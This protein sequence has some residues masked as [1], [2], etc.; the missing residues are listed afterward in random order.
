MIFI[1]LTI[2]LLIGT[3]LSLR[4]VELLVYYAIYYGLCFLTLKSFKYGNDFFLSFDKE[5]IGYIGNRIK[6]A[7]QVITSD[8]EEDRQENRFLNVFETYRVVKRK[9]LSWILF[10]CGIWFFYYKNG[11]ELSVNS[12]VPV[13]SCFF[14]INSF[15]VG[16][17]LVAI[18]LNAVLVA[19][20][21]S[22]DVPSPFYFLYS[23]SCFFSLYLISKT[24][25][26]VLS[27]DLLKKKVVSLSLISLLFF[28][29]CFAFK[30]VL[31]QEFKFDKK[32]E[33]SNDHL[34]KLQDYL[35]K[36]KLDLGDIQSRLQG[37][38]REGLSPK[39]DMNSKHIDEI[40]KKLLQKE[41][42]AAEK[43]KLLQEMQLLM[44]N[45]QN[46][47]SDFNQSLK[48]GNGP[49]LSE[50]EKESFR[51]LNDDLELTDEEKNNL[52]SFIN[53]TKTRLGGIGPSS[54]KD[55]MQS[56]VD[57]IQKSLDGKTFTEK[58]QGEIYQAIRKITA[59]QDAL[60]TKAHREAIKNSNVAPEP[61]QVQK[62]KLLEPLKKKEIPKESQFKKLERILAIACL[63][64]IFF[65]IRR[66]LFKKGITKIEAR[67]PEALK[68]IQDEWKKI[69]K[70]RL[71]PRE[72]VIFHY[73]LF[74][75]SLQKIH[76][77]EH[78]APP[79]C[80][81]YDDMKEINPELE[82]PTFI[83]TEVFAQCFY[84]NKEVNADS[85][86]IF[87][88]ALAKIL[89]VYQFSY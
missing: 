56:E 69:R 43:E 5:R 54:E 6:L 57:K 14:I 61:D 16:H 65:L 78:E 68:A 4:S 1:S 21:F 47:K 86:K 66:Y 19:Y 51:K 88:K 70:L 58:E 67:D 82:K 50:L 64:L 63:A 53:K 39:I 85:L 30:S 44:T 72:E 31:P 24:L 52:N 87:R 45:M 26:E 20:N 81:I 37:L 13:L 11:L 17:L 75:E 35:S 34:A 76:Y 55:S 22:T 38:N 73:N 23:L 15:F 74:H 10:L 33:V 42:T 28:V 18:L 48:G 89:R 32:P 41:L 27:D 36:S 49:E 84:G 25:Q 7:G 40:E 71:S 77:S 80:R 2:T 62:E 9:V 3:L 29:L 60:D 8:V 83:I 12:L 79:S 59:T 46:L